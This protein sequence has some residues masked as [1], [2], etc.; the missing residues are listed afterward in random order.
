MF[1]NNSLTK[2]WRISIGPQCVIWNY[3]RTTKNIFLKIKHLFWHWNM[4]PSSMKFALENWAVKLKQN[5]YF[6]Y[7][8]DWVLGHSCSYSS[9]NMYVPAKPKFFLILLDI[10]NVFQKIINCQIHLIKLFLVKKKWNIA[11]A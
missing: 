8:S 4:M 11:Y 10:W 6:Q 7:I 3:Q 1:E 2:I 9:K 5:S